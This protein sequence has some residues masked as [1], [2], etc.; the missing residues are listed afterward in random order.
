VNGTPR[1][2]LVTGGTKGIGRAVAL[3]LAAEGCTVTCVYRSDE[4]AVEACEV[5]ARER[6][7]KLRFER[8]D[9]TRP[10]EV[11]RL[12]TRLANDDREP[13][14]LINAAGMTRDAAFVFTSPEDLAAV[15]DGN[16]KPTF[17]VCQ[18]AVKSMVRRRF[19]RI[20]NFASPAALLGNE[21]QAA[22]A[23]AK[24]GIIGLT[25]SLAREFARYGIT[26]NAVSPGIVPTDMTAK[27]S[28]EKLS[29]I[30]KRTPLQRPGTPE[31]VAGLVRF[32]CADLAGYITGQCLSIDGGLT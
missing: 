14:Y 23:A 21:G 19:G 2:A 1:R 10:D 32:L 5:A 20:V 6:N 9:L 7:T 30:L 3:R 8:A 24:A 26:V 22:Y 16:L 27:L 15:I 13:D 12:F 17:F 29:A 25:R 28:D 18:Q 11:T 4:A 31:E